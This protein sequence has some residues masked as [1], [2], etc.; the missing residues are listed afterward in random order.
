MTAATH[1]GD[2]LRGV[3]EEL[4]ELYPG[5][6]ACG[7]FALL[8]RSKKPRDEEWNTDA[9]AR[10]ETWRAG[11]TAQRERL[12]AEW[13]AFI[14]AHVASGGNVGLALPRGT[15]AL[16]VEDA[17]TL[18]AC[19]AFDGA[20][21]WSR[22]AEQR[23]HAL[24][25]CPGALRQGKVRI[26]G[27]PELV[28]SRVGGKGFLACAPSVHPETG[29]RYGWLRGLPADLA[30]LPELPEA[31]RAQLAP[32]ARDADGGIGSGEIPKG[33][34]NDTLHR[35]AAAMRGRGETPDGILDELRR[36]NAERC[37]PPLAD[38]EL[39]QIA[40]SAER[41]AAGE[42]DSRP[43]III[44]SRQPDAIASDAVAALV[45]ANEPTPELFARGGESVSVVR[46]EDGR[47]VI[48]GA[49]RY[50]ILDRLASAATWW[51]V[52][53]DGSKP[54][55]PA[56][57]LAGVVLARISRLGDVLPSLRGV[58]QSPV[59]LEDGAILDRPGYDARSRLYYAPPDG[60]A[61][62]NVPEKPSTD[63][64]R[65]AGALLL[66]ELL[67]EFPFAADADRAAALACLLTLTLRECIPGCVPA[68]V[69]DAPAAGTGK[70]L[71]ADVLAVV[72]TG[73]PAAKA[74]E[75][76][77]GSDDEMRKRITSLLREGR[78]LVVL[79]NVERP[80]G[81]P[82]LAAALT[83][84]VW[85][86]RVLGAS[87]TVA[88]RNRASWVITGNNVQL[89]GD[90]P[91]RV[92]WC[93]LDAKAA[94]PWQRTGFRHPDLVGWTRENRPALL[95]AALTLGR[96]WVAAGRPGP[97]D[98]VPRLGGFERWRHVVGGAL[99]VA[100]VP[101]FLGNLVK[102][103]EQNDTDTPAWAAFLAEWRA[104]RADSPATVAELLDA[105][106]PM[107]SAA[108]LRE[109]LPPELTDAI[110]AKGSASRKVGRAFLRR[111]DTRYPLDDGR[112][113][114]LVRTTDNVRNVAAW[115]VEVSR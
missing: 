112:T 11:D 27:A 31:W 54:A 89:R 84:E 47:P 58:T 1:D 6:W 78:A 99:G 23:G 96:A 86:D 87:E 113:V 72:T 85:G 17:A 63:E 57:K 28:V 61:L 94:R 42:P 92:Y 19:D 73:E 18:R 3:L 79:D 109:A 105:V 71:L 44:S 102:V 67:G 46:D 53:K 80:L 13:L 49:T 12:R 101:G 4:D 97:A 75:P 68:F 30:E 5:A 74:A 20:W 41:Y 91:R 88:I 32:D 90:I 59:M 2:T 45:A 81:S 35:I 106:A 77:S 9:L 52:T 39:R 110:V 69:A 8:P 33:S 21:Q 22:E 83:A 107:G 103:Y 34:R 98:S 56:E 55:S 24:F 100:G 16:D 38:S 26:N 36:V 64:V 65:A 111:V 108:R 48:R 50:A 62:P 66:E 37:R 25:R 70:G 114:R 115:R 29:E 51:S 43:R 7:L 15:V 60:F 76:D 82:A 40:R 95:G 14:A 10:Y 104:W 93:R